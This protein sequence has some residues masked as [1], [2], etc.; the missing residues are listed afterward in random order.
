MQYTDVIRLSFANAL[1]LGHCPDKI[2]P[3]RIKARHES[4][5]SDLARFGLFDSSS[6]NYT[7]YYPDVTVEDLTPKDGDFYMPLVRALSEVVVHKSVNP[8]DFS[9]NAV[10]KE[11]LALLY[12]QTVYVDHE[13]ATGNAIGV[14]CETAWE[15]GYTSKDNFKVPSGINAKLKIDGKS[16][17][18]LVRLMAMDPPG[19]HSL[20]VTVRFKWVPSHPALS[21]ED[22]YSKLGQFD[23]KGNMYT[24]IATKVES[25][26][27]ISLVNHGADPFAQIIKDGEITN[28]KYANLVYNK[29]DG[30]KAIKYA[31]FD[32]RR[33]FCSNSMEETI[34][35]EFNINNQNEI[36]ASMK[37]LLIL[38]AATSGISIEGKTDENLSAELKPKL[39]ELIGN[40]TSLKASVETLEAAAVTNTE[41]VEALNATI[42][43]LKAQQTTDPVTLANL[44]THLATLRADTL[45]FYTLSCN[46][47][48]SPDVSALIESTDLK[49]LGILKTQYELQANALAPLSCTK[50]GSQEVSRASVKPKETTP[51]TRVS[52]DKNK[53]A[54]EEAFRKM[55]GAEA[56]KK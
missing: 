4:E 8:V 7:N 14:I 9:K 12:G 19:I 20:S 2:T 30:Q 31:E 25:Y 22:F 17:P 1:I 54:R 35:D 16:N 27:E 46:G 47:T 37:E 45:K 40:A 6:P 38:L 34:L 33:D 56:V 3:E 44:Q 55:H 23:D 39:V 52:I 50:C 51:T 10:L 5:P 29:A 48:V 28:P 26:H 11:S 49:T 36:S 13:T 21:A 41:T 32:F 43:E 42:T 15:E 18:R 53:E 24:R